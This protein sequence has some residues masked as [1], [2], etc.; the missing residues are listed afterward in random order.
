MSIPA[1][2]CSDRMRRS[3]NHPSELDRYVP[4]R[5]A[6]ALDTPT[7]RATCHAWPAARGRHPGE[8]AVNAGL[9]SGAHQRKAHPGALNLGK[10]W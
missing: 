10:A 1:T 8:H 3:D 7:L 6:V 9:P 2:L 4:F 5:I